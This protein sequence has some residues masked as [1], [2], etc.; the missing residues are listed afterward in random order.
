MYGVFVFLKSFI[1]IPE[2][3]WKKMTFNKIG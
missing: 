3:E 1:N 2:K